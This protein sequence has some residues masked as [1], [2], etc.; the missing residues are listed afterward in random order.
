MQ[1]E[2]SPAQKRLCHDFKKWA[3]SQV[4]KHLNNKEQLAGK[5]FWQ[6]V[7]FKCRQFLFHVF[8]NLTPSKIQSAD[9][10]NFWENA[11]WAQK[12]LLATFHQLLPGDHSPVPFGYLWK[13]PGT[14]GAVSAHHM[15]RSCQLLL[16]GATWGWALAPSIISLLENSCHRVM[17]PH[18]VLGT[19]KLWLQGWWNL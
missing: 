11:L 6:M 2:F 5:D 18:L 4:L 12:W 10:S 15:C 14:S 16:P 13:A 19:S 3:R 1:S 9:L 8:S 7:S 17:G